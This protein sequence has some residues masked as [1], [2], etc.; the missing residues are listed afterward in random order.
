MRSVTEATT[1]PQPV[2][3]SEAKDQLGYAQSDTS[4][5]TRIRRLIQAA[6]LQWQHDT[7]TATTLK[8]IDERLPEFPLPSWRMYYRPVASVD[9]IMYF[10]ENNVEQTLD[11]SAYSVDLPNRKIYEAVDTPWP[12]T[13]FRWDAVTINYTAGEGIPTEI[14]KQAILMQVDIMEEL[15]GTTKEKDAAIKAYEMLAIRYG[16]GSYP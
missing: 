4:S 14:S 6:T 1:T 2:S 13:Q 11:P 9:S 12:A 16:R 15:R 3:L 10:D 7:Q 8:T 5:D